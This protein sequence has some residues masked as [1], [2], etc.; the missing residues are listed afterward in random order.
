MQSL[1]LATMAAVWAG[2]LPAIQIM[3]RVGGSQTAGNSTNALPSQI[4]TNFP[5]MDRGWLVIQNTNTVGTVIVYAGTSNNAPQAILGPGG[6][7]SFS[8]PTIDDGAY[9]VQ[10]TGAA[11]PVFVSEGWGQ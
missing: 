10:S 9:S 1:A 2:T 3:A 6:M 4:T 8:W 7:Y 11:L 5:G